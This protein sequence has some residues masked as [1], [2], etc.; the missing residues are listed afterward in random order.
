MVTGVLSRKIKGARQKD[1]TDKGQTPTV[2]AG[3]CT[4]KVRCLEHE[5]VPTLLRF[6]LFPSRVI[7]RES[8]SCTEPKETL[9]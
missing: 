4:L 8:F 9:I 3:R 2:K 6:T 5:T 1:N 7:D